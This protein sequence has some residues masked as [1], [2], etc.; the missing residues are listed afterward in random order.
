MAFDLEKLFVDVF[1]PREGEVV[2][3][4]HDLP[5]DTVPDTK[6]W[7]ERRDMARSWHAGIAGLSDTYGITVNPPLT[8]EA[9]GTQNG[10]LP[11]NGKLAEEDVELSDVIGGSTVVIAMT[12]FSA[13]APLFAFVKAHEELR[14]ASMPGCERRME[15]TGLSADYRG[16][17]ETCERMAPL[18]ARADLI[19]VEFSTGHMCRY[20][21]SG[22]RLVFK[23]TG[24]LPPEPARPHDRLT[25]LPAG[26]VC[27]NPRE[28]DDSRT[29]GEIPV[30][31]G[32]E[33]LLFRVEH[34]QV[35]GVLGDG[36]LADE[37]RSMF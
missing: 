29:A 16:I 18:F 27:V 34:N 35:V 13:S 17:A 33:I 24:L 31:A 23:D 11:A 4:M 8:Y 5:T 1:S 19:E 14:V 25:N 21:V 30:A 2:T 9:T 6:V 3:L 36:P 28:S 12:E 32:N 22:E 15:E 37:F 10:E 20:D 7:R 26:E